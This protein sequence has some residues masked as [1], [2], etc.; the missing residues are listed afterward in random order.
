MSRECML[1]LKSGGRLD[2]AETSLASNYVFSSVVIKFCKIV[3][4][5]TCK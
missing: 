2:K 5:V 4:C 1:L 3:A